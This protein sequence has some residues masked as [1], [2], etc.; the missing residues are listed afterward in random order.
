M[1]GTEFSVVFEN[2]RA[3]Y[4][5]Y[6][7]TRHVVGFDTFTGY[8]GIGEADKC[9]TT[10]ADGVYGV[11]DRYDT[12]LDAVLSCHE[13]E[14]VMSHIC[15]HELVKGDAGVCAPQWFDNNP[16]LLVALAFFDMALYEPTKASLEAIK[17][18]L[19]KGSVVVF[20]ELSNKQYPGETRAA[21][22][23]LGTSA[24]KSNGRGFC[25]IVLISLSFERCRRSLAGCSFGR[26]SIF[27]PGPVVNGHSRHVIARSRRAQ[28]TAIL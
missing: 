21:L 16:E 11:P 17:P 2:L 5:P 23:V 1:V 9:S 7:H 10:I 26:H 19:F 15:K 13:Q 12:Y 25:L 18:K 20:D 28:R 22:E 8:S 6:N 14:N 27:W 24:S 3:V 4:E